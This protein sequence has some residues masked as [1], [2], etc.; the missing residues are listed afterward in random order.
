MRVLLAH[1]ADPNQL[2]REG[3]DAAGGRGVQG[4]DRDRG[5]PR[6]E[7]RDR[8]RRVARRPHAAQMAAAFNRAEMIEWLLDR[9]ASADARD[10]SGMSPLDIAKAM[11]AL[12]AARVLSADAGE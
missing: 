6:L 1:G 2:R 5:A 9:G 11:G 12:D 3:P 10:A 7:R 8:R 4:A